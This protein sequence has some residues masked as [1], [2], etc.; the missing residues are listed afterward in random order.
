MGFWGFGEQYVTEPSSILHQLRIAVEVDRSPVSTLLKLWI[1]STQFGPSRD[2]LQFCDAPPTPTPQH[3]ASNCF[4]GKEKEEAESRNKILRL[5]LRLQLV[6]NPMPCS[7]ERQITQWK[8]VLLKRYG[9]SQVLLMSLE[10]VMK[11][12]FC[13]LSLS[14]HPPRD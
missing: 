2:Q 1:E 8:D 5:T 6:R 12:E 7:V 10:R 11:R 9:R 14:L 3:N 13:L 4:C